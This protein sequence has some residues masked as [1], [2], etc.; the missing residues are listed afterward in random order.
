[1]RNENEK[2]KYFLYAR[3]S[4]ESEDR[5]MA[6]IDA[7]IDEL[8]RLAK[9]EGLEVVEVFSESKSAKE[10]GRPVFNQ[11]MDR[12]QKGEA[13]GILCWKLNRLARN[14]VDGGQISW[15]LQTGIIRQIYTFGKSYYP[16][17]NV[18]V[19]AVELGMANQFIRDLSV[20]TARGLRAKAERGW[21]PSLATLGYMH[22][23]FKH[24]GEKEIIPDPER[25]D[26]V[27]KF[28][29]LMLTGAYSVAKAYQI[30]TDDW[31]LRNKVGKKV[32]S[33][34]IHRI[35][36]DPF[37]YGEFEYPK[38]SGNWYKG[39]H[40]P[41]ITREE[42][43]SI[44]RI[45]GRKVTTRPQSYEFAFRGPMVCGECGALI[46]A[47]HKTKKQKNGVTRN[48]IYYHCTKRKDRNCSQKSIEEKVLA[49]Q[50]EELLQSI[51]IPEE[52]HR[53][54]IEC[55]KEENDKNAN[56]AS[57]RI[58]EQ[59][60]E[61]DKVMMRIHN[62]I[63]MRA[64]GEIGP[65]DFK[66]RK[67]QIEAE[68]LRLERHLNA[69][70]ES[71]TDWVAVADSFFDFAE[72]ARDRFNNGDTNKKKEILH[73][74][75][76]NLVLKDKELRIVLQKPLSLIQQ[77]V[78]AISEIHEMFEPQNN[79]DSYGQLA[80]KYANSPILLRG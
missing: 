45:L 80:E 54:A 64:D 71:V 9:S 79:I 2:I 63:D 41:M 29:D 12:V 39:A 48:Y 21:Y 24:K 28:F 70:Q 15:L 4:S 50:V 53:W 61:Y 52:F 55:L 56:S 36:S 43:E 31:G 23:P 77:A 18:I 51:E 49:K 68:K 42:F 72:H 58:S 27:R 8:K 65:E 1:M 14:P 76:S 66:A 11:M 5:Q 13:Q 47:E 46:T 62:L 78:P 25:F 40:E 38:G 69:T 26:L 44:Q 75:G 59:R 10:P 17:D 7:Q 33:S 60:K 34:T 19:M 73:A 16:T 57:H 67:D 32:A 37:Y 30:A 3:K 22:N 74:L 35:L 20:D 6:S